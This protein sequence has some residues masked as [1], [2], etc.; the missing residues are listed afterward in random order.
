[1]F[2]SA[3]IWSLSIA[4]VVVLF[5]SMF[6]L[7]THDITVAKKVLGSLPDAVQKGFGI[8][9]ASFFTIFG[10]FGYLFTYIML[11]GSVQAMNLG[12]GSIAREVSG[13][14][15]DFL[16]TKPVKRSTVMTSKLL[17]VLSIIAITNIIFTTTSFFAARAFSQESFDAS[18]LLL[19]TCTLFFVQLFF[20]A[21]GAF[22]AVIL[23][24]V[25]SVVAVSLPVVFTFFIIGSIG[26]I[27]GEE[28]S[29]YFTPFKYYDVS[30]IISHRS[31][32]MKYIYIELL[33]VTSLII[34]AYVLY[35]KKDVRSA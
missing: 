34:A 31:Y 29:R 26:A 11:I 18:T 4:V 23:P 35:N 22:F 17:A 27:I 12:V 20:V 33:V 3:I 15:A 25:K 32:E 7:F 5:L 6:T 14:T 10:F 8:S 9:L 16:L 13:K 2:K 19:I 30:Y 21:L 1:M 28:K 24:R